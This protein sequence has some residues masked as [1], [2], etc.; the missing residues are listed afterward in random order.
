MAASLLV[1]VIGCALIVAGIMLRAVRRGPRRVFGRKVSISS[2]MLEPTAI[3]VGIGLA[4]VVI[5]L[6]S[7]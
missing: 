6:A 2:R 7:N 3:V 4:A 5:G 1:V